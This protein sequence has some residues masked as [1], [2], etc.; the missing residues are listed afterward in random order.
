MRLVHIRARSDEDVACL[1]RE[2]SVYAPK[3]SRRAVLI[4]LQERSHTDLLA[5]LK[6]LE[7]CLSANEIR[8]VRVEIDGKRYLMAPNATR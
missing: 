6:A 7:T 8:T 1:M 5:L 3:R 4:E 2:L